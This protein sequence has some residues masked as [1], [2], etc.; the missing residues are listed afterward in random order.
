MGELH[1]GLHNDS[2]RLYGIPNEKIEPHTT[3]HVTGAY[4]MDNDLSFRFGGRNIS[5]ADFTFALNYRGCP[6]IPA[7]STCADGCCSWRRSTPSTCA[8]AFG[9]QLEGRIERRL[10]STC[11]S[12][13]QPARGS[14]PMPG[15]CGCAAMTSPGCTD[16]AAPQRAGGN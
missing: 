14:S 8:D 4:R 1:A 9:K 13:R 3:V 7:G 11:V 2:L 5:D 12:P 15:E 16:E 10:A 6:G